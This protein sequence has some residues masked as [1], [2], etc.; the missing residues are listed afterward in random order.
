[1]STG[2][3]GTKCRKNIAENLNR[4]SKAHE[5]CRRQTTDG[6]AIAYSEREREFTFAKNGFSVADRCRENLPLHDAIGR[7]FLDCGDRCVGIATPPGL[8]PAVGTNA[9]DTRSRKRPRKL[10]SVFGECVI[11][12][13]Y[14]VNKEG[15]IDTESGSRQQLT[16]D[17]E[18]SFVYKHS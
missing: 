16:F 7:Q 11:G 2:G 6:R 10:A 8:W 13:Y 17:S 4:L 12:I 14:E 1:M 18:S 9:N 3:K 15:R 5:R